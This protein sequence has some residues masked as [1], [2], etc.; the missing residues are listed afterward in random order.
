MMRWWCNSTEKLLQS[1]IQ[2][3]LCSTATLFPRGPGSKLYSFWKRGR[4]TILESLQDANLFTMNHSVS[5]DLIGPME[6][7]IS[8]AQLVQFGWF[9]CNWTSEACYVALLNELACNKTGKNRPLTALFPRAQ[10]YRFW[11]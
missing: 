11:R 5:C 8:P 9:T 7:F 10:W 3:V 4:W 2:I 6:R 1:I